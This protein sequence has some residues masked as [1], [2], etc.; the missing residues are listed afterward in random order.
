[1][2]IHDIV[3]MELDQTTEETVLEKYKAL[4]WKPSLGAQ[5]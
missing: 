3:V 2:H 1:L 4:N 5:R